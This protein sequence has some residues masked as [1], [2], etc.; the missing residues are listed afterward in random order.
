MGK[1][2][3]GN[4]AACETMKAAMKITQDSPMKNLAHPVA[5]LRA[6]GQPAQVNDCCTLQ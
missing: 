2:A 6:N 4:V 5:P 3:M 1:G